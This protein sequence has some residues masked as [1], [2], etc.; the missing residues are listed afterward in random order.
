MTIH[1]GFS[2]SEIKEYQEELKTTFPKMTDYERLQI[3]VQL[4][5]NRMYADAF[6]LTEKSP[7]ALEKIAMIFEEKQFHADS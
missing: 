3:A 2:I 4:Q 5:K 1:H 6:V 7:S